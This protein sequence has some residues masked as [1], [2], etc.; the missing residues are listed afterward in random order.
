MNMLTVVLPAYNEE[1]NIEALVSSWQQYR[2]VLLNKYGLILQI[3]VVNDG[4]KDKTVEIA[5]D[6]KRKYSNFTLVNHIHNKGLGEAVKTG[7]TFLSQPVSQKN[8]VFYRGLNLHFSPLYY[9]VICLVC[10]SLW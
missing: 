10:R 1:H 9:V 5:E 4:S 2:E 3:V 7:I 6:L 8:G